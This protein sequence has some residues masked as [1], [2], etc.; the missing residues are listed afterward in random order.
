MRILDALDKVAAKVQAK[1]AQVAIA[2]LIA[3]PSVTAP[4]ASATNLN[5]LDDLARA[6]ELRL[7]AES[8]ELLNQASEASV[9]AVP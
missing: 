7:D 9:G 4:I 1:P 2:W 3:R 8:I 6:A 5:Q